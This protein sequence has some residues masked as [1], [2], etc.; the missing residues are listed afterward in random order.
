[1]QLSSQALLQVQAGSMADVQAPEITLE[2]DLLRANAKNAVVRIG[3]TLDVFARDSAKL[4][5]SQFEMEVGDNADIFVQNATNLVTGTLNIDAVEDVAISSA[6]VTLRSSQ[7]LL[8]EAEGS[9]TVAAATLAVQAEKAARVSTL[10]QLD[11][12]A[13]DT[14]SVATGGKAL[15]RSNKD[16]QVSTSGALMLDAR[17]AI[18]VSTQ[19]ATINSDATIRALAADG[20]VLGAETL[21]IQASKKVRA[22]VGEADLT[23]GDSLLFRSG[24]ALQLAAGGALSAAATSVGVQATGS[25]GVQGSNLNIVGSEGVSVQAHGVALRMI[26][27]RASDSVAFVWTKPVFFDEAEV[28]LEDPI[29]NSDRL[30]IEKGATLSPVARRSDSGSTAL[31]KIFIDLY[32]V[33][34]QRWITVWSSSILS[35]LIE[36]HGLSIQFNGQDV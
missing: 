36:L 2:S 17:D 6:N 7:S 33:T 1:M 21:S 31:G 15:L 16:M 19:D 30:W 24:G 10:K 25:I 28:M 14:L 5:T 29:K 3:D 26:S 23:V 34:Q 22:V 8:A 13:A 12:L 27:K 11:I 4:T 18:E 9:I 32:S 35:D 20:A